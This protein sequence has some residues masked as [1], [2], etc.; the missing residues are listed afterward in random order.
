MHDMYMEEM[1]DSILCAFWADAIRVQCT[2]CLPQDEQRKVKN[3]VSL[4]I[5]HSRQH[6]TGQQVTM[7]QRTCCH[8][9]AAPNPDPVTCRHDLNPEP[10]P[11]PISCSSGTANGTMTNLSSSDCM[12]RLITSRAP[13]SSVPPDIEEEEKVHVET[14]GFT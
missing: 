3:G 14:M 2:S 6:T 9:H 11:Y 5:A 7:P 8:T 13:S 10:N 12:V 1:P 4:C